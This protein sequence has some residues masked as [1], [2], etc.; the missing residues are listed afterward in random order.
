MNSQPTC[1]PIL[2]CLEIQIGKI[3]TLLPVGNYQNPINRSMVQ[4]IYI[5]TDISSQPSA[6]R[7]FTQGGCGEL[8]TYRFLS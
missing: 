7:H 8:I 2:R 3:W 6:E 4:S 1:P 5:C